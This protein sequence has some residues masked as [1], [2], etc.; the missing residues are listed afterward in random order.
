MKG[1]LTVACVNKC[2]SQVPGVQVPPILQLLGKNGPQVKLVHERKVGQA[3]PLG[4]ELWSTT[5]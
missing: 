2:S 3:N 1:L 5:H 4:E